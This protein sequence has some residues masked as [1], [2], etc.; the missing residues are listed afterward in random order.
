MIHYYWS[1][2]FAAGVL[3]NILIVSIFS[4]SIEDLGARQTL[5]MLDGAGA[6]SANS[7]WLGY[8]WSLGDDSDLG[9]LIFFF[10]CIYIIDLYDL[11]LQKCL[12]CV[13]VVI[14]LSLWW[15]LC[16]VG[17]TCLLHIAEAIPA[18]DDAAFCPA[19]EYLFGSSFD[20]RKWLGR[21][22]KLP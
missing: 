6:Y 5:S 7:S 15:C 9:D 18:G 4:W 8:R 13:C 22:K 1:I 20:S 11:F 16:C 2:H 10:V 19:M 17:A 12:S 21:Q 14:D 3:C